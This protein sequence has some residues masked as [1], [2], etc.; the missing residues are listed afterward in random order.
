M[1]LERLVLVSINKGIQLGIRFDS[2]LLTQV[3]ICQKS[4]LGLVTMNLIVA[5]LG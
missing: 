5:A 3:N 2:E 1:E 4:S